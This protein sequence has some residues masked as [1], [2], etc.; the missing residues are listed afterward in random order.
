MHKETGPNIFRLFPTEIVILSVSQH[1]A[2]TEKQDIFCISFMVKNIVSHLLGS[3]LI[4]GVSELAC[5]KGAL[6]SRQYGLQTVLIDSIWK[7]T[8]G[9][10][11]INQVYLS[12]IPSDKLRS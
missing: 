9:D 8:K 6:A 4:L 7:K 12:G 2:F 11:T 3:Q 10:Y 5:A 1:N